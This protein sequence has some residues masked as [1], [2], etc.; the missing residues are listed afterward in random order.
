MVSCAR[1]RGARHHIRVRGNAGIEMSQILCIRWSPAAARVSEI[2]VPEY[3]YASRSCPHIPGPVVSFRGGRRNVGRI[4]HEQR[5]HFATDADCR[6]G[7]PAPRCAPATHQSLFRHRHRCKSPVLRG[8]RH[9][10]CPGADRHLPLLL[11]T[12]R[13]RAVAAFNPHNRATRWR[14]RSPRGLITRRPHP[15][16]VS[17]A[18]PAAR[19]MRPFAVLRELSL[20]NR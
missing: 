11:L 6:T 19:P 8:P 3:S 14:F 15:E 12:P 16:Y 7:N 10:P 1:G 2:A 18:F 9:G 5:H 13:S 17:E 20:D 4:P